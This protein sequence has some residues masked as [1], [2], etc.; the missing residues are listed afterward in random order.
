[1]FG[2]CTVWVFGLYFA[3]GSLDLYKVYRGSGLLRRMFSGT[4]ISR[5]NHGL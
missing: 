5:P 2:V 3:L 1:M 4:E